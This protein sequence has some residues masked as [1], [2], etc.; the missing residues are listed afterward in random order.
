MSTESVR[1]VPADDAPTAA[2][3]GRRRRA[4]RGQEADAAPGPDGA[5]AQEAFGDPAGPPRFWHRSHP[6]FTP[7]AGFFTGMLL[8]VVVLGLLGAILDQVV[9][10]DVSA[11]P[12]VFLLALGVLLVVNLGLVVVEGT[13]R[14]ARYM[15]FGILTT[16]AVVA[17]VAALTAWILISRDG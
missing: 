1:A 12:W 16:P 7:L 14:F 4:R 10:Y 11:H 17:A 9:G 6:V 2:R 3:G 13:R 15:L 5:V 8:V